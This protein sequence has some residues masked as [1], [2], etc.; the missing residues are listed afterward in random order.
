VIEDLAEPGDDERWAQPESILAGRPSDAARRQQRRRRN[1]LWLLVSGL[2]VLGAGTGVL[3]AVLAGPGGHD[4]E[5]TTWQVVSGFVVTGSGVVLDVAAIVGIV[6]AGRW[7]QAWR[8]PM[9]VLSR[10]QQRSLLAQVRGRWPADPAR[11]PLAR[12]LAEQLAD[13]RTTAVLFL[14]VALG[15]LGGTLVDPD[16]VR[17]LLSAGLVAAWTVAGIALVRHARKARRFLREHPDPAA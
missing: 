8:G 17:V 6:R 15:N 14:G 7:G 10:R 1:L 13:P 4:A 5:P 12:H 9:A 3:V 16:R 2:V 11:L